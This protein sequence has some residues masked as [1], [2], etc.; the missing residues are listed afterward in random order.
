MR[1]YRS[2]GDEGLTNEQLGM[3]AFQYLNQRALTFQHNRKDL[4]KTLLPLI[5]CLTNWTI[6]KNNLKPAVRK[7]WRNTSWFNTQTCRFAG[8]KAIISLRI[9][10]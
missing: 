3:N 10:T 9:N 4:L 8:Q 7:C 2:L 6:G 1:Y 5:K